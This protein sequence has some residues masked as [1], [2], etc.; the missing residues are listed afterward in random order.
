MTTSSSS[1]LVYV[2]CIDQ[3]ITR[4]KDQDATG[5]A[6]IR[7]QICRGVQKHWAATTTLEAQTAERTLPLLQARLR[8]RPTKTINAYC[9]SLHS[10]ALYVFVSRL[11]GEGASRFM[12][13]E[14]MLALCSKFWDDHPD[15]NKFVN[16]EAEATIPDGLPIDEHRLSYLVLSLL[17][18]IQSTDGSRCF[19]FAGVV[20]SLGYKNAIDGRLGKWPDWLLQDRL[21][22]KVKPR[23]VSLDAF[24]N[25][26][27]FKLFPWIGGKWK[28][29]AIN[30]D[31]K[32]DTQAGHYNL[33]DEPWNPD[34]FI[35][36]KTVAAKVADSKEEALEVLKRVSMHNLWAFAALAREPLSQK[37]RKELEAKKMAENPILQAAA[38]GCQLK[39]TTSYGGCACKLAKDM[40]LPQFSGCALCQSVPIPWGS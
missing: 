31:D 33:P 15:I 28:R 39:D 36:H 3:G 26:R 4:A 38:F 6:Q 11:A 40:G 17:M 9:L 13:D 27:I 12:I 20:D 37:V 19:A 5:W 32:D 2:L 7:Q 23:A 16:G 25:N 10:T 35:S 29:T 1:K 30:E 14:K 22:P 24:P 34:L 21:G 8:T 18:R